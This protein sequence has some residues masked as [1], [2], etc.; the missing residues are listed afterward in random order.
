MNPLYM[1]R[2]T[3]TNLCYHITDSWT[4]SGTLFPDE[5]II[6]AIVHTYQHD[7]SPI[8]KFDWR[9]RNYVVDVV[10]ARSSH[11]LTLMPVLVYGEVAHRRDRANSTKTVCNI[12][13]TGY[14][15]HE[16]AEK[17]SG[18]F[19]CPGCFS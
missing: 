1:L 15:W 14:G 4:V 11:R 19:E 5:R 16:E 7:E 10:S 13:I 9:G 2:D 6:R 8:A 3:N 12:S 18:I 17:K